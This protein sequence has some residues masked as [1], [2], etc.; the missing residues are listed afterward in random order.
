MN[1]NYLLLD[2]DREEMLGWRILKE[3]KYKL[4]L[5]RLSEEEE[6]LILAIEQVFKERARNEEIESKEKSEELTQQLIYDYAKEQGVYLEE[7]Q[8]DYLTIA[9]A[10]HI[11]GF[12]FLDEL[13]ADE[14]IEEISVVGLERPVYVYIRNKGWQTVNACFTDEKALMDTINKMAHS[15][16]RRITLQNPRLD[17]ILKEGSRLHAS[18]PPLSQGEITIRKFR[19]RPYSPVELVKNKT[20]YNRMLATLSLIMQGDQSLIIAGNTASGKTT[21]LNALFSFVPLDDRVLI[22]EE[23]PEINI[24]HTHQVRLVANKELGIPLR[25][26]V[27]DSLRMRPDRTIVG[28]VRNKDEVEAL[29]DVLHGGQARGTYATIHA[30]SSHEALKRLERFGIE[31]W[32]SIDWLLVQKR[33]LK[34]RKNKR[35]EIRRV[36]E[37]VHPRS[38]GIGISYDLKKDSWQEKETKKILEHIG[39]PLGLTTREVNE[40]IKRRERWLHKAPVNF[41][42][43]FKHIQKKCYGLDYESNG[44]TS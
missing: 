15:I 14:R 20:L 39:H 9:A 44:N 10:Q 2:I 18:L 28:E 11:Y 8:V 5:H 27:Y 36:V 3:G 40:E 7:K 31:E 4:Q 21:L 41:F 29:F 1:F 16:G 24:P 19:M 38:S 32:D 26:L 22:S 35:E 17:A 33:M 25:E 30:Q 23:T 34:F 12:G 37:L 42:D 43:C 6:Q 13:L